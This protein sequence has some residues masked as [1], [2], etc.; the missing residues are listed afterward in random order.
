MDM[1]SLGEFAAF[2]GIDWADR[3]HDVCLLPAGSSRREASVLVHRPEAIAQWAEGLRERFGGRDIAVCLEL[4]KGPLVYALQPYAF[5]VLFPINPTTLAKYRQ[6]FHVSGAKDDPSDAQLAL[7]LVLTHPERFSPLRLQSPA[8]RMLQQLVEQRRMLVDDVRRLTNRITNALKQYFPQPLEWFKDKDT[9]VFCDFLTHWPTLKQA[10]RARISRLSA[11]FHEHNVRYPHIVE[12]R[13]RAIRAATAL[14]SDVAVIEPNR[15]LAEALVGQLRPL[16]QAVDRFDHAIAELA[17]TLS[18]YALFASFPGAGPTFAPRLLAA[19]G[20]QR[21]RYAAPDE[22]QRYAGIAPVTERSGNKSW[23][24]WR[25]QCPKFLRQTF[26]EWAAL[27]IPHCYWAKAYYEQQ[28]A[29]GS[30]HQAAL[31]SLAFKW[32]RVA[33][34]CWQNRT[35]YD[36]ATYLNALKRR[37]S[38]LLN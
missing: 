3:K 4:A 33:Y 5:L 37:G 18:D 38:P 17:P 29:R 23:V 6:T 32:I 19:F 36:E 11:F 7:E 8:M 26:V 16:L 27:S 10:Q 28:R 13:I 34:R 15:M 9:L 31:R 24:H 12:A 30:S 35:P 25:L 22:I 14:T 20:E 2:V 1:S 21:E